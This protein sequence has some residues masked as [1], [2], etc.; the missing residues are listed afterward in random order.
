MSSN[1]LPQRPKRKHSEDETEDDIVEALRRWKKR[2]LSPES[3]EQAET[4][5]VAAIKSR[6]NSLLQSSFDLFE[7]KQ[8]QKQEAK[9]NSAAL[10]DKIQ[11][12]EAQLHQAKVQLEESQAEERRVQAQISDFNFMLEYG[13]WY[14]FFIKAMRPHEFKVE[15]Y[16]AV[17]RISPMLLS[18]YNTRRNQVR[19]AGMAQ[20]AAENRQY[21]GFND[22]ENKDFAEERKNIQLN[23]QKAAKWDCLNGRQKTS[24]HDMIEAEKKSILEWRENGED[25]SLAPGTAFLDRIGRMCVEAG[26]SRVQC[27]DWVR[28]YAERN[29]ACHNP[30]PK[31]SQF[32]KKDAAGVDIEVEEKD[33]HTAIDWAAMKSA[34]EDRKADIE[35]KYSNGSLSDERRAYI[36]E[37][38]DQFWNFISQGTEPDGSPTPTKIAKSEAKQC[39]G[40]RA[41][42]KPNPPQ[43]YL[44]EYH[45]GKWDDLL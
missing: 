44:Q 23:A 13:D 27:L 8:K 22:E 3:S 10:A 30:P 34:V 14:A 9:S 28:K 37:L 26:I 18:T 24:S 11:D 5:L 42:A 39:W 38:M 29:A 15:Q 43:D 4:L 25:Q 17:K 32:W 21:I 35:E 20:A 1:E 33:A 36:L 2:E 7:A 12:L 6:G 40:D 31:V 41:T 45:E 16:D 19:A